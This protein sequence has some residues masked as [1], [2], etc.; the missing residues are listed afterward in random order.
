M[1]ARFAAFICPI[2]PVTVALKYLV[3]AVRFMRFCAGLDYAGVVPETHGSAFM[4]DFFL[5]GH[6]VD[7]R[8]GGKLVEFRRIRLLDAEYVSR[9]LDR[10]DL[11]PET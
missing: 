11:K 5:V 8:I 3:R 7:Y 2:P 10:G 4:R 9:E 6:K 1:A